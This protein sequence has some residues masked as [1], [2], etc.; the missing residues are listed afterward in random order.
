MADNW[1]FDN[2]GRNNLA[3]IPG[4]PDNPAILP[5]DVIVDMLIKVPAAKLAFQQVVPN[6]LPEEQARLNALV[7]RHPRT[8]LPFPFNETAVDD[9]FQKSLNSGGVHDPNNRR[10]RR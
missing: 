4:D 1:W 5:D 8:M 10:K 7:S 9:Q 2:Q 3:G 6:M